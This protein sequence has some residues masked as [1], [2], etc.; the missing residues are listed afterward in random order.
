MMIIQLKSAVDWGEALE[1]N[2]AMMMMVMMMTV[3]IIVTLVMM[4]EM[5][6]IESMIF[7]ML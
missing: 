1:F 6:M 5:T 4:T 2:A 7:M 3:M